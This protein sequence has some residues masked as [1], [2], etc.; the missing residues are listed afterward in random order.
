MELFT[1]EAY[2]KLVVDSHIQ[3]IDER[4]ECGEK[5]ARAL[6]FT[7]LSSDFITE[8]I[9]SQIQTLLENIAEQDD[10]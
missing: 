6:Y 10:E 8:E 2:E 5:H 1:G 4:Y 7:A 9:D 3:K